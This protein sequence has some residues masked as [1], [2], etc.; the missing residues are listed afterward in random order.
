THRREDEAGDED[1]T[2]DL[3]GVT[4]LRADGG[5]TTDEGSGCPQV[6]GHL[7]LD[8]EEEHHRRDTAHHDRELSVQPH[9]EREDERRTE[10]RDDVL[11]TKTDGLA[12][13]ETFMGGDDATRA[14]PLCA[15]LL[16]TE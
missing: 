3:R 11:S 2:G 4:T 6:A 7:A 9:D 15:D 13:G 16:P 12:P 1:R 5:D 14:D 10:H 8:D